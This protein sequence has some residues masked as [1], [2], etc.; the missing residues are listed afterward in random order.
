MSSS[1]VLVDTHALLWWLEDDPTLPDAVLQ[2]I[3]DETTVPLVSIASLWEI[4]IKRRLGKLE[5]PPNL[6][7]VIEAEG[8]HWLAIAPD[9]AWAVGELP[10]IHG[11]PFDRL[12][13]AQAQ[14]ERVPIVSRDP[15]FAA[16][17]VELIWE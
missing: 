15:A 8:F 1:R 16:Y 12:L 3:A 17:G 6:T 5:A 13:I 10:D 4:A 2:L 14:Q 11:D 9:H 7:E